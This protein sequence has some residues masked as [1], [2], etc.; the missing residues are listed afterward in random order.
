MVLRAGRRVRVA[1]YLFRAP[2]GLFVNRDLVD[3]GFAT[4][5]EIKPNLAYHVDFEQGAENARAAGLGLWSHC[6][7]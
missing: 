3:N 5:L 4:P 6:P 1:A 7:G 2:D